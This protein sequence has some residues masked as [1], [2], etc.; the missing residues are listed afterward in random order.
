[1]SIICTWYIS[2]DLKCVFKFINDSSDITCW[3]QELIE[4]SLIISDSFYSSND[5]NFFNFLALFRDQLQLL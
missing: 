2:S 4:I 3:Q 5:F 1:M